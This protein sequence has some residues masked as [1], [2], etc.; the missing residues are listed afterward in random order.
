[1]LQGAWRGMRYPL[2]FFIPSF[3]LLAFGIYSSDFIFVELL[4]GGCFIACFLTNAWRLLAIGLVVSLAVRFGMHDNHLEISA[5]TFALGWFLFALGAAARCPRCGT[6]IMVDWS[7]W[8]RAHVPR[9]C[10]LCGRARADVWPFQ[11]LL[12][13]EPWDGE[14]HDEGGGPQPQTYRTEYM[15]YNALEARK[16]HLARKMR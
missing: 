7:D 11:Y 5:I 14:Y 9:H 13:P 10:V 8:R 4:T 16:K 15:M 1:M 3:F 6:H 12:K 2:A